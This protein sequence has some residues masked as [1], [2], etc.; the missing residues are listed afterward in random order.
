MPNDVILREFVK[1]CLQATGLI[2]CVYALRWL[3]IMEWSMKG[4]HDN[5]K[6][7][8]KCNS[9]AFHSFEYF[10]FVWEMQYDEFTSESLYAWVFSIALYLD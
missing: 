7:L 4:P 9:I 2:L 1:F 3:E 5:D 8:T 6:S 10:F